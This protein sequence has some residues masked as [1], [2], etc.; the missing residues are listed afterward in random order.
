MSKKEANEPPRPL[1]GRP[2]NSLNIGIVGLPNVGK[3]SLFNVLTK[4][5]IPAENYPFCTIEPNFSRVAVPDE[6]FDWLV[7]HWK[8]SSEVAASCRLPT[9]LD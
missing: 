4:L 1:L 8:P 3:S 7:N 2:S 5:S 9:L 6:R